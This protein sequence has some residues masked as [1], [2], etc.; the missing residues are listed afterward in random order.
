MQYIAETVDT[1]TY[2][3][4]YLKICS[5]FYV[6]P[7]LLGL[8]VSVVPQRSITQNKPVFGPLDRNTASKIV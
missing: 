7:Y 5:I 4:I 1:Y 2:F 6:K 8:R 3:P